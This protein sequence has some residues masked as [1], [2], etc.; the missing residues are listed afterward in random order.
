MRESYAFYCMVPY[1]YM[2]TPMH[3]H[4]PNILASDMGKH[5]ETTLQHTATQTATHCKPHCDPRQHTATQKNKQMESVAYSKYASLGLLG[6]RVV[7][8]CTGCW[9][10]RSWP[11]RHS[12]K[13]AR[14]SIVYVK[15]R[16]SRQCVVT[17]QPSA[18][19]KQSLT[20]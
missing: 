12:Q 20:G 18:S 6:M 1:M 15:S 8:V 10:G 11:G 14:H 2:F 13:S 7:F 5:S 17:H 3:I 19:G 9:L 4:T 16:Y